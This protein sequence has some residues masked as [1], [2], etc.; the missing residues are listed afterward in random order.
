MTIAVHINLTDQKND[1]STN[2]NYNYFIILAAK[3]PSYH[4]IFI[5]DK[6]FA[7]SIITEKN[8]TAVLS[9][10]QIRNRLLQYYFYNFKIP[11][12][13]NKYN[14][15]LFVSTDVCSLRTTVSQ[16]LVIRDLSFLKK[17]NLFSKADARY[18]K[19]YTGYFVKRAERIAVMNPDLKTSMVRSYAVDENKI[20]TLHI[21]IDDIF[22]PCGYQKAEKT[23]NRFTEGKEYFLFFATAAAEINIITILKAFSIFKK[24]QK[25]NMQLIILFS[26]AGMEDSIKE[27]S[28]YK[29][30]ADVKTITA[31]G[32]DTTAAIIASAYA[33]IYLPAIEI[34]EKA[35]LNSMASEVPLI[36]TNND[37][38]KNIYKDG[39][40]YSSAAEKDLAEKM[41]LLYKD[42][43]TRHDLVTKGKVIATSHNWQNAAGTLWQIIQ[44]DAA[45]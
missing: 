31:A 4:F 27:L 5:F 44:P 25:S 30:R 37:F 35:G 16:C 42:E 28:S 1:I 9:G 34:T 23:R 38:C 32:R 21:G 18:L 20:S 2:F 6:P 24:W 36:T 45:S 33:A 39:A 3:F 41:M 14:A 8:I 19:K 7:P 10:P 17:K 11:R 15:A 29:Y 13:L 12:L 22:K 43:Q 26:K 40:L